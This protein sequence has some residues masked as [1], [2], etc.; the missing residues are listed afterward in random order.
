MAAPHRL[1]QMNVWSPVAG[2]IL[3]RIRSCV[4]VEGVSLRV[5][6]KVSKV[7]T[8]LSVSLPHNFELR[9]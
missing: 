6:F 7:H 4:L 5:G 3:G 2:T 9:M 1:I 8:R